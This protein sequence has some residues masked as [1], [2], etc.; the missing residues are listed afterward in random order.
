MSQFSDRDYFGYNV[1][2]R[3]NDWLR[4]RL[5][6][7]PLNLELVPFFTGSDSY[8][9][10]RIKRT[11]VAVP[12]TLKYDWMLFKKGSE[13]A[14]ANG[15]GTADLTRNAEYKTI[16]FLKH[17]SYTDEYRVDFWVTIGDKSECK[18]V[19]DI[20]ITSRANMML[21]G[22]WGVLGGLIG[23]IVGKLI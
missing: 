21:N 17:F 9:N 2:L 15:T 3:P 7:P 10:L 5:R 20:E 18:T 13:E 16:L 1:S 14:E 19:A 11:K 22:W 6:F 12:S 4:S 8:V 23:F